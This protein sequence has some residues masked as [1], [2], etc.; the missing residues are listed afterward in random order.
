MVS[1]PVTQS[2]G[3]DK[4]RQE[5][6]FAPQMHIHL[7]HCLMLRDQRIISDEVARPLLAELLALLDAGSPIVTTNYLHLDRHLVS[8]LGADV[9]GQLHTARSRNDLGVTAWRMVL[10][11]LLLNVLDSMLNLRE[12]LLSKADEYAE[13]VM[14]GYS[15]SQHAQPITLGY[16]LAAFA[17]VLARD[18]QRIEAAYATANRSPLGAAA[19]TT[20]G[21]P[22]DRQATA[23]SLGFDGLV[24]NAL[25]AVAS[26]DDAEEAS[27]ALAVLG[28]HLARTA[29]DLFVWHTFE[30]NFIAFGDEYTGGSSIMPQKKNPGL[31]EL[32][33]RQSGYLIGT[34][35]QVLAAVR[36]AWFTD[37]GDAKEAGNDPLLSATDSAIA[38][39]DVLS[40]ALR[41]MT[42]N[43][44]RMLRLAHTGFGTMTEVADTIV[45]E[46]GRSF[47]VAHDIVGRTVAVAIQ[48][49]K[50]AD[51]ITPEMLDD[52][53][54]EV[55][56]EPLGVAHD[57]IRK[58]L[59][60]VENI[61]IRTV[62]G[63][64][65]PSELRRMLAD[66]QSSLAEERRRLASERERLAGC[67]QR[68]IAVAREFAGTGGGS[69][70]P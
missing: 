14:P 63:G 29:E 56:N 28:V 15:H 7:A 55:I 50:L 59:D 22:I 36:G 54:M 19:L 46:T 1:R 38:C 12:T 9:G 32:I 30:F 2:L 8:V 16:Y 35:T 25:D 10:R 48:S 47:R 52:A 27:S 49:G 6:L 61:R 39:L 45:R 62:T 41:T 65:A 60:P 13:I 4:V 51:E 3:I 23:T 66:R 21:F 37:A 53:S 34:S 64:P 33:K 24:E 67:E 26:R 40:G 58:A 68:L 5:V 11:G 43:P 31:L 57:A 17:D 42:I 44:E 69:T 20:T 70:H 18:T